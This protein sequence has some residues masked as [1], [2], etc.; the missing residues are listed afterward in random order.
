[1]IKRE[2]KSLIR[3]HTSSHDGPALR[4]QVCLS[5][6]TPPSLSQENVTIIWQKLCIYTTFEQLSLQTHATQVVAFNKKILKH[7]NLPKNK[8]FILNII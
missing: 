4:S 1:M 2:M 3:R 8:L 5:D 6:K 7:D